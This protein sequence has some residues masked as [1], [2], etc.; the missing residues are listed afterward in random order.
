[1]M[2]NAALILLRR[3]LGHFCALFQV[4]T[5]LRLLVAVLMVSDKGFP[6]WIPRF[7]VGEVNMEQFQALCE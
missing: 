4:R 6:V 1:M 2:R 5:L 7:L 3:F